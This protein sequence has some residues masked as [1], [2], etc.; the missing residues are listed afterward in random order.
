MPEK[1]EWCSHIFF[2]EKTQNYWMHI[3]LPIS[4]SLMIPTDWD[5][6][7]VAGCGVSRPEEKTER[8]IL[9]SLLQPDSFGNSE[10]MFFYIADSILSKFTLKK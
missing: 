8:E 6:C 2:D 3:F 1:K 10:Q 5:I 4:M 9:L 7:P